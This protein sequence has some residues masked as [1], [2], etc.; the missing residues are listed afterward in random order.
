MSKNKKYTSTKK[1][2]SLDIDKKL[3]KN[4]EDYI[5]NEIPQLIDISESDLRKNY[6]TRITDAV[7]ELS[8]GSIETYN[9]DLFPET[10]DKILVRVWC[11]N[12]EKNSEI[13]LQIN[14]SK[15][16]YGS[17]IE[18]EVT[19]TNPKEI[20]AGIT[21]KLEEIINQKR[22]LNYWFHPPIYFYPIFLPILVLIQL[23]Q[24]YGVRIDYKIKN[25]EFLLDFVV[26]CYFTIFSKW[27]PKMAFDTL[28]Q[29]RNN[30]IANFIL[31]GLISCIFFDIL[32]TDYFKNLFNL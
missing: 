27:K 2:P 30:Q 10:T 31:L 8:F 25:Y 6:L 17:R 29:K 18:L 15:D 5:F 4:I 9:N 12:R 24:F 21:L 11:N 32:F 22:N 3:L 23:P 13:S 16:G 7:G 28:V 20:S 14:F 1:L 19:A 26:I